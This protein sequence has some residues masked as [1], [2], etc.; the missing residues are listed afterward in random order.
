[1][2]LHHIEQRRSQGIGSIGFLCMEGLETWSRNFVDMIEE[3]YTR[4]LLPNMVEFGQVLV[5]FP[6]GDTL[7]H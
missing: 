1:M 2:L 5:L 3:A 7:L 4:C 6:R